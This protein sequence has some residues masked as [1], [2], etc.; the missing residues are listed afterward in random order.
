MVIRVKCPRER[1]RTTDGR[2]LK[3]NV[4]IHIRRY[5]SPVRFDTGKKCEIVASARIGD[6][7]GERDRFS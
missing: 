3:G 7:P 2:Q 5:S 6:V 4:F 1:D